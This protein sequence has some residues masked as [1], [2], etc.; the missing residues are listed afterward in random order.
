MSHQSVYLK[1][2]AMPAGGAEE[3]EGCST[4][5]TIGDDDDLD[6]AI[7]CIEYSQ[8]M[9]AG[10]DARRSDGTAPPALGPV[11]IRKEVD[12]SSPILARMLTHTEDCNAEFRFYR[13]TQSGQSMERFY[14][15]TLERARIVRVTASVEQRDGRSFPVEIVE[16][17]YSKARWTHAG[18]ASGDG[19]GSTEHSWDWRDQHAA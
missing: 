5:H 6:T 1:L 9:T 4:V 12:R 13:Q 17:A 2:T 18:N 14:T 16:F 7:E 8:E 3:V 19:R 11:R 15:V 10:Y